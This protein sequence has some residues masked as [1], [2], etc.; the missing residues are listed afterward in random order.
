MVEFRDSELIKKEPEEPESKP[1]IR[2]KKRAKKKSHKKK[3]T[4]GR[5]KAISTARKESGH[6]VKHIETK[7]LEEKAK[8]ELK[9]YEKPKPDDPRGAKPIETIEPKDLSKIATMAGLGL[10]VPD[11]AAIFNMSKTT[12][13]RRCRENPSIY[14]ALLKGRAEA[15]IG[16]TKKA[17]QTAI[18]GDTTM[19]IF[20]LKTQCGFT[21]R[22]VGDSPTFN[23]NIEGKSVEMS[24]DEKVK[25]LQ[26]KLSYDDILVLIEKE[27]E[28]K[29]LQA[30][31]DTVI[32]V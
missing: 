8:K 17:Y 24:K 11:I 6:P 13:E 30:S 22:D 15:R 31:S 10:K 9:P 29:R 19:L 23:I 25:A 20:L 4:K 26:E 21:D 27:R 28:I 1:K 7:E 14:E 5:K 12:F 16:L 3:K 18:A 32:D 2:P